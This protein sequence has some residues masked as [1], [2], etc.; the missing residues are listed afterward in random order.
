MYFGERVVNSVVRRVFLPADVVKSLAIEVHSL[1]RQF[2]ANDFR[3][4]IPQRWTNTLV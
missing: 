2:L 3:K 4:R 1:T